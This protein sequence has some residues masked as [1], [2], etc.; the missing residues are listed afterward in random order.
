MHL[1]AALSALPLFHSSWD[2]FTIIDLIAA[3]TNALNG[4]LLSRRPDHYKNYTVVGIILM[5]FLGGIGGG[6]SRDV[7]LNK[8]PAAFVNPWYV[9]FCTLAGVLGLRLSY[10]TGQKFREGVFGLMTAFSLPWYAVVGADAA[11]H[12]HL[13]LLAAVVIGVIG[14]TAG[15]Y[16]IDVT[17]GVTPK[18]FVRGEW[19]VGTAVLASMLYIFFDLL[20]LDIWPATLLT[21]AIAF[22]F[23]R[24]AL[25]FRWEEPEPWE[26]DA[27]QQSQ[28]PHKTPVQNIREDLQKT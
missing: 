26:P 14:P 3:S 4:A 9:V 17:S 5:A 1:L 7:I 24:A 21:V 2:G 15:R 18:H 20:G 12:A 23:R 10:N 6:V 19:F 28:A 25:R 16:F 13:P 11:L 27:A 22:G 8:V